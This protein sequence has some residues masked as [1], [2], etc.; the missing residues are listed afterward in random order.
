M[1]LPRPPVRDPQTPGY[2]VATMLKDGDIPP[3]DSVGNFVVGPTHPKIQKSVSDAVAI[4][5]NVFEFSMT[6]KDSQVY[7]GIARKEGTFGEPD[8]NNPACLIV[9]T[10]FPKAWKRIISV[11]VPKQYQSGTVAPFVIGTDGPDALLF[12]VLDKLIIAKKIPPTIGI[13]VG[14]G[15][16]DA[17]GSQ[18]GLE[19]DT[20]S[21]QYAE[22]VEDEILPRVE[23]VCDV[24]LSKDPH[25]RVAMGCSSGA[26]CAL[27]MAWFRTDLYRRVISFSGTYVNQQWPHDPDVPGGAWEFHNSIIPSTPRKPILVWLAVADRDLYNSNLMRDGMHD[28]VLA[29]QRMAH[30]LSAKEYTYQFNFVRNAWHC[31]PSMRNQLLAQALEWIHCNDSDVGRNT[32]T[33]R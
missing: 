27:S 2:V 23:E 16:G 21:S 22:F 9:T 5:G 25:E 32:G 33:L 8:P 1:R 31:D 4:Q 18:R 30:V 24:V 10:S 11:Y 15:G 20:L 6:S 3:I 14:N 17:Q 12:N 29:N 26:A 7:P 13:S 19:Y 28:W